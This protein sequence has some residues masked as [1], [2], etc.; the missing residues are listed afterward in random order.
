MKK[1][2]KKFSLIMFIVLMGMG[3][4][5]PVH[6]QTRGVGPEMNYE[7]PIMMAYYRTWRDACN[8]S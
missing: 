6:A 2:T 5:I 8:A 3:S 4:L 7:E 1:L